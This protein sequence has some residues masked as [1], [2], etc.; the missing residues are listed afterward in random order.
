[1]PRQSMD[2]LPCYPEVACVIAVVADDPVVAVIRFVTV[3]TAVAVFAALRCRRRAE[4]RWHP[5]PKALRP[6]NQFRHHWNKDD[7]SGGQATTLPLLRA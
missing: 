5:Q 3:F 4:A 2:V 7:R 6:V 1:M